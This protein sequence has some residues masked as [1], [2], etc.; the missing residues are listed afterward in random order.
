MRFYKFLRWWF[1]ILVVS[2]HVISW[3]GFSD[4][5]YEVYHYAVFMPLRWLYDNILG[6]SPIP[7]IYILMCLILFGLIK[8]LLNIVYKSRLSATKSELKDKLIRFLFKFSNIIAAFYL[9]WGF[10]YYRPSLSEILKLPDN[11]IDTSELINEFEIITGILQKERL[12]LSQDTILSI[13][14]DPIELEN[15]IRNLEHNLLTTLNIPF[16]GRVRVRVLKPKGTLLVFSTAGIYIPFAMEGHIDA[17]LHPLKWP[18]TLAHEM[19][20]GYGF[21]DEGECNFI[22][23]LACMQSTDPLIR[24]AAIL[25]YWRYLY[26]RVEVYD[27]KKA[28]N[29]KERLDCRINADMDDIRQYSD[30]YTDF[31]PFISNTIYDSYLKLHG[32]DEGINNYSDFIRLIINYKSNV[33]IPRLELNR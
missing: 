29:I 30:K 26:R 5:V 21:T 31:I 12:T 19:A 9:L 3:I 8:S 27:A 4:E 18:F 23:M 15:N 28:L 7:M 11:K 16:S 32:I 33:G 25:E 1:V 13:T 24:Y 17:G 14:L 20:H 22:A 6:F 2:V 10:N